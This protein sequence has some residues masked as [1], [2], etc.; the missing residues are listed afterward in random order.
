MEKKELNLYSDFVSEIT[1][2]ESKDL[3]SFISRVRELHRL[4]INIPRLLTGS[5][6]SSSEL[7]EFNEIVKKMIF[8]GKPLN[9]ENKI[10]MVKEL[11]DL[12]WYVIQLCLALNIDPYEV[13]KQNVQKLESR[14]PGGKFSIEKSENRKIGDI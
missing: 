7:G 5:I 9:E 8:Q 13:I 11:G 10:H 14:Y 12:F 4:G 2:A 6:G 1:S 3:E